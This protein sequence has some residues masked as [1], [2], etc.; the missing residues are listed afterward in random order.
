VQR[1]AAIHTVSLQF[2]AEH[3]TNWAMGE[4]AALAVGEVRDLEDWPESRGSSPVNS[5]G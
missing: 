5:D 3:E 4:Q 1:S 2:T